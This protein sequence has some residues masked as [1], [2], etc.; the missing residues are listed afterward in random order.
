M[1]TAVDSSVLWALIKA[2]SGHEDW[3]LALANAA[4]EGPLVVCPVVFAE[5][6][7]STAD[8]GQLLGFLDRLG[9]AYSPISEDAAYLAGRMFADYRRAG[10]PRQHLAPDFMIAAHATIQ[11]DR[12]A[13]V[14]RGYLRRWF[15]ELVLLGK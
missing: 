13:A 3:L 14:D 9:I 11:A 7:P 12:L 4:G 1:I 15:P 5:L 8:A 6:A 2:E 10:G